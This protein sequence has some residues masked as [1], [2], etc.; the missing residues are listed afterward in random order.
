[1]H[2]DHFDDQQGSEGVLAV[3]KRPKTERRQPCLATQSPA[4]WKGSGMLRRLAGTFA[5]FGLVLALLVGCS[6]GDL[7]GRSTP[8]PD[9]GTYFVFDDDHG[10]T[11]RPLMLDGKE[12][13]HPAKAAG[14]IEPGTH[15]VQCG[16]GDSGFPV[17]VATGT[18]YY[19]DY[20]GP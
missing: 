2:P 8:S 10:G 19:F 4:G 20:W 3:E 6:D 9:G 7:R 17:Q 1:M 15:L 12:W 11:C 16:P 18:T 14:R 13:L 5:A